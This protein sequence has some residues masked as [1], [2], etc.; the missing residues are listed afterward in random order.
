MDP[1][2]APRS[3]QIELIAAAIEHDLNKSAQLRCEVSSRHRK[4]PIAVFNGVDEPIW[5]RSSGRD[6]LHADTHQ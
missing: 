6:A 2:C 4:T 5:S 3:V 1:C